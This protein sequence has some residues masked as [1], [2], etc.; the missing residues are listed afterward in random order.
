MKIKKIK[1]GEV[2][3][4]KIER[5]KQDNVFLSK[6]KPN[7]SV[8]SRILITPA[9]ILKKEGYKNCPSEE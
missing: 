2:I 8:L 9:N 1:G 4:V 3:E 7:S 6:T 5:K